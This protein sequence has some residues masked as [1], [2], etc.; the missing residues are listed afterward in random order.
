M[1][2][3]KISLIVLA[4]SLWAECGLRLAGN[5]VEPNNVIMTMIAGFGLLWGGWPRGPAGH[6]EPK[7]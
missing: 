4:L 1:L 2:W 6:D 7:G 5:H 3:T